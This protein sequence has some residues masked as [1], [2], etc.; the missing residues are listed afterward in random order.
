VNI[1]VQTSVRVFV[2]W[3]LLFQS[4]AV[5]RVLIPDVETVSGKELGQRP[6]IAQLWFWIALIG[7][8]N[9]IAPLSYLI[10]TFAGPGGLVPFSDLTPRGWVGNGTVGP[11]S[12]LLV[13]SLAMIIF[14][15]P[16][17]RLIQG[18]SAKSE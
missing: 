13:I 10:H 17:G 8:Y 12:L 9:L 3:V 4:K 2:A 14:C 15:K 18:P 16:I 6:A 7:I 1:L 11:Q 5:A